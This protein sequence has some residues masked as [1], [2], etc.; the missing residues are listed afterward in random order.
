MM[1]EEVVLSGTFY[2]RGHLVPNWKL[3]KFQLFTCK[4]LAY[5]DMSGKMLNKISLEQ[6]MFLPG[7]EG[8][9]KWS[10]STSRAA[11]ALDIHETKVMGGEVHYNEVPLLCLV[12]ESKEECKV[13]IDAVSRI[14]SIHKLEVL[15]NFI[16]M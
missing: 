10:G 11:F 6:I 7:V 2:K 12:F 4:Q 14:V 16:K 3:R 13:F 8:A 15:Y 5:Y 9:V 1:S